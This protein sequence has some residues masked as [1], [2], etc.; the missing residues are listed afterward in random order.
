MSNTAKKVSKSWF[1][2]L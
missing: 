1:L 2:Q